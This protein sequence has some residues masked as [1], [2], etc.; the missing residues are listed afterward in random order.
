LTAAAIIGPLVPLVVL[1]VLRGS[2]V[3]P[4]AGDVR[5]T[6]GAI[7]TFKIPG[8]S[9]LQPTIKM[10]RSK[11]VVS[12]AESETPRDL[13]IIREKRAHLLKAFVGFVDEVFMASSFLIG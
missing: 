1:I 7:Q 3:T 8:P 10:T 6:V 2:F 4:L 9:S 12:P 5:I 11:A 13:R